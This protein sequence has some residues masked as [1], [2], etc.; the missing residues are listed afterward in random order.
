MKSQELQNLLDHVMQARMKDQ[1]NVPGDLQIPIEI[2][3][4]YS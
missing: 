1:N 2:L 3:S 4:N